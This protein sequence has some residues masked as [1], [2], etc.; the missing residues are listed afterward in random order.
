MTSE[1][2][3]IDE[4][5]REVARLTELVNGLYRHLGIGQLDAAAAGSEPSEEI[6]DALRGGQLIV[7]IKLYREQTGM[8][9]AEAKRAVED[10]ARERGL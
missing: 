3:D 5:K 9:L 8:G 7:A 4:L 6:L 2:A 1:A 10:I